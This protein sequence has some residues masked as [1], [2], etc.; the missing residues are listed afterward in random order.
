MKP[1]W[2]GCRIAL[3]AVDWAVRYAAES[4]P[5][6][7]IPDRPEGEGT[8][9]RSDRIPP[10]LQDLRDLARGLVLHADSSDGGTWPFSVITAGVD[11]KHDFLKHPP[12]H[13]QTVPNL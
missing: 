1:S 6:S 9:V 13:L 2:G 3:R 10:P 7:A 11:V 4:A 8:R 5:G 12:A